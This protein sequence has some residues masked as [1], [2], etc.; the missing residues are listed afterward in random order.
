MGGAGYL[1]NSQAFA[2]L[3]GSLQAPCTPE[4][5][6]PPPRFAEK[7]FRSFVIDEHIAGQREAVAR[8]HA[9][10]IKRMS[11]LK[12]IL[13]IG[14]DKPGLYLDGG[15]GVGKTH[16]LAASFH[17]AHGRRRY[18]SFAEAISLVV[19]HGARKAADLLDADLCCIDEFEL[20]DPANVRLADL[21]LQELIDR[22]CRI[23]T[24]SNT[25]PGELGVGRLFVDQF[26]SQLAR[27]AHVFSDIHV[28]GSDFRRGRDASGKHNPPHWG[29]RVEPF[30]EGPGVFAMTMAQLDRILAD[31]PVV[32]LRRLAGQM[33]RLTLL[34][35]TPFTDQL[36]ALRFVHF[37][38]KLYDN[39][40]ELNVRSAIP[41]HALFD[42]EHC[43]KAFEKKYLRCVSRLV[44]CCTPAAT[45]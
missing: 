20:D 10:A 6:V 16:L 35:V 41:L 23:I 11:W 37:I 25:V 21:L 31:V 12:R 42:E 43:Q 30:A 24:T 34:D 19:L 44:E 13:P 1:M 8:V 15:F 40:V 28:P 17:A 18:L 2:H 26:R 3:Q 7:S 38:D 4:E 33:K 36:A 22:D 32:N 29:P 5:L 27:I 45:P 39:R 14:G 9:F